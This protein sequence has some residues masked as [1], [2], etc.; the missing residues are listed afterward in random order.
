VNVALPVPV[1]VFGGT[2]LDPFI[3]AVKLV[4]GP[5]D[6]PQAATSAAM[7]MTTARTMAFPFDVPE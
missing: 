2:S 5:D 1:E 6:P 4:A 7:P 3:V